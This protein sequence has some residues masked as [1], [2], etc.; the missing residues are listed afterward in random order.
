[1]QRKEIF[2]LQSVPRGDLVAVDRKVA[3]HNF[4]SS[5]QTPHNTARH[6]PPPTSR[7][8]TMS[9]ALRRSYNENVRSHLGAWVKLDLCSD[10][11]FVT[12]QTKAVWL[13]LFPLIGT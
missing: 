4:N 5:I 3:Q 11:S 6:F 8:T 10:Q 12:T 13:T 2:R 9:S 7:A 1:M